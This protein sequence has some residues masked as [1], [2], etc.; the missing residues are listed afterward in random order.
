MN[1]SKFRLV[2]NAGSITVSSSI[3]T[4]NKLIRSF[5]TGCIL[6]S[7]ASMSEEEQPALIPGEEEMGATVDAPSTYDVARLR[8]PES[9]AD[10]G[11]EC[12]GLYHVFGT[13]M[14]RRSN[15]KLIEAERIVYATTVA[16][17]FESTTSG[18]KEYLMSIDAGGI[19]C[20]AVHPSRYIFD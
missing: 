7:I 12:T 19:G 17:V 6:C 1:H 18:A 15:L 9:I 13:D 20:V 10:L 11:K 2:N 5:Q 14:S 3:N 8:P 4:S 16:V